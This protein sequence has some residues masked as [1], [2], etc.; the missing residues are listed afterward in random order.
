MTGY[1]HDGPQLTHWLPVAVVHKRTMRWNLTTILLR[2]FAVDATNR[3]ISSQKFHL[4]YLAVSWPRPRPPLT[5]AESTVMPRVPK[6]SRTLPLTAAWPT[7][8]PRV[9]EAFLPLTVS[10]PGNRPLVPH[11]VRTSHSATSVYGN[12]WILESADYIQVRTLRRK[13]G[14]DV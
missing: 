3:A 5:V 9:P 12:T 4:L 10:Q 8:R 1:P 13:G 11:A 14:F 2:N 6:A 7:V